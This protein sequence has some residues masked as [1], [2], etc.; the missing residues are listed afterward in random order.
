MDTKDLVYIEWVD[1]H[2]VDEWISK[3]DEALNSICNVIT[4]GRL[5]RETSHYI[6][7]TLNWCQH[8]DEVSCTMIIPRVCIKKM[9]RIKP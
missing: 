7:L 3:D 6:A 9:E 5:I 4:V 8:N 2:S 1:P